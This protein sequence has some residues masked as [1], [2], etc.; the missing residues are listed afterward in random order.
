[1]T[2]VGNVSA[3]ADRPESPP[4]DRRSFLR[5]AGVAG[6]A[7][8]GASLGAGALLDACS[9]SGSSSP[10]P[11]SGGAR[12]TGGTRTTP[13]SLLDAPASSSPVTHVVVLMMENRSFDHWLG[14]LGDDD[15]YREGGHR[16]YGGGFA[17]AGQ[18]RQSFA[19]PS[20]EVATAHLPAQA[21]EANPFRGCGHPDPGHNWT[22]GRAERD[23]GFLAPGSG[24]DAFALGYYLA[25]DLPFTAQ[26]ARRFTVC[27]NS[28]ASLLGGT[29]PNRMYL[30][31]AQS[32]GV[33]LN[34]L[35]PTGGFGWDTIWDRL[36]RANVAA[37]YYATDVPMTFMWG[38][39]LS[40]I[41]HKV[42][43]YFAACK[44]GRLP[45][46]TFVDP[47]FVGGSRTDNHPFGDIHA[48]ERFA[49]DVFAAF[50]RS[51]HWQHGAFVLTYDEWGGFFDHVRPPTLPDQRASANDADN[52]GQAGFRVPTVVASPFAQR[53]FVDHQRYDHTSILR[54]LEWRF[55]GAPPR[56]TGG[57]PGWSLTERD[58]NANSIGSSLV[59]VADPD[60]AFDLDVAVAAP[61]AAC[62][63]ASEEGISS[64]AGP[65]DDA[66]V[67]LGLAHGAAPGEPGRHYV[68]E[69]RDAGYF[70]R[71][72]VD[73]EPS[74][75]AHTWVHA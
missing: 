56:G 66:V 41:S 31:G 57:G 63:G 4:L 51:P 40:A 18:Q 1:M 75:M 55:L 10:S 26:L 22:A 29:L 28:F 34:A 9:S 14:W 62:A 61:T 19:G 48:G 24:N 3:M 44:A 69:L 30:H 37:G 12:S 45:N 6:G 42:D 25:D 13:S 65:R 20:G 53:G 54:F 7:L 74:T 33:K 50:A 27:D 38:S 15:A 49:R 2:G 43:D 17:V 73:V 36:A 70:E 32:G 58:R 68:E 23:G 71:N 64:P 47:G 35:P 46:V 72:G 39:R 67:T 11:L 21:S 59:A 5:Q 8:L 60:V 52:F 16:R